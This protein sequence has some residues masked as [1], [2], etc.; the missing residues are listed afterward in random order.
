MLLTITSSTTFATEPSFNRNSSDT[1]PPAVPATTLKRI[2]SHTN[3]N[4]HLRNI[5]SIIQV[6]I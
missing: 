1:S 6:T 5:T 3:P 4:I 2:L